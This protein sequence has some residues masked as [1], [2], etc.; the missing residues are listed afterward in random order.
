MGSKKAVKRFNALEFRFESGAFINRVVS[1]MI[2]SLKTAVL[3][4]V[5][6]LSI[7]GLFAQVP[8]NRSFQFIDWLRAYRSCTL[9]KTLL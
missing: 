2:I 3:R 6:L 8:L 1:S 7:D 5:I 4:C 9:V